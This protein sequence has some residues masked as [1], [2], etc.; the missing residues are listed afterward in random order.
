MTITKYKKPGL[1]DVFFPRNFGSLMTDFWND[2]DFENSTNFFRPS[3]D[4][5]E[6]DKAFEIHLSIPGMKKEEIKIDLKNDVL[7]ISGERQQKEE[8]KTSKYHMGEIRYGKFLRTFQLPEK[9]DK[10]SIEASFQDGILEITMPKG[11]DALP[12]S[13]SIK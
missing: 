11:E 2:A 9:I 8:K 4:I 6:N 10:D 12:T 1:T 7:T 3:V 13:I 5:L